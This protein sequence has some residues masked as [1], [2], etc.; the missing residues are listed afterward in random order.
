M[1]VVIDGCPP[2]LEL[3]E[4]DLQA[5]LDRRRPGQSRITTQ[6]SEEDRAEILSGVFDGQTT[7]SPIAVLV[8][9]SDARSDAYDHLRDLYR[10]S[11]ADYIFMRVARCTGGQVTRISKAHVIVNE[12]D[13]FPS[14]ASHPSIAG[15]VEVFRGLA[16]P[17]QLARRCQLGEKLLGLWCVSVALIHDDQFEGGVVHGQDATYRV[18]QRLITIHR[19]DDY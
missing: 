11:H 8:R 18:N 3:T 5:D 14:S 16:Q 4:A 13:N 12:D 10:P 7:G 1:G 9:N 15:Y 19:G 17:V 6:R 2:R